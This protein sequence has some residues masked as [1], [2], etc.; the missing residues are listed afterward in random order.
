MDQN[1][2]L[3]IFEI[4][5]PG[6]MPE[7]A[8]HLDQSNKKSNILQKLHDSMRKRDFTNI[9]STNL[10]EWIQNL[11]QNYLGIIVSA[12]TFFFQT[13][14][15]YRKVASRSTSLLVAHLG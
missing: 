14:F 6:F 5:M 3:H 4:N 8:L 13:I 15:Q 9:W 7:C 2:V 11:T 12:H 10:F 1:F